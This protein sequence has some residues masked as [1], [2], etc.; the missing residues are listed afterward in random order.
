MSDADHFRRQRDALDSKMADLGNL[1]A[2]LQI[3]V[4][5]ASQMSAPQG[6]EAAQVRDA[7][8]GIGRAIND[9]MQK[10]AHDLA[11]GVT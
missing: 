8:I 4:W 5:T 9:V 7:I 2:A 3:I 11:T 1:N 6:S 10:D